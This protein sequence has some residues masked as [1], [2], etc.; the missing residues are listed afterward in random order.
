[1]AQFEG[2]RSRFGGGGGGGDAKSIRSRHYHGVGL[3]R[4]AVRI[5]TVV[6]GWSEVVTMADTRRFRGKVDRCAIGEWQP[7]LSVS[8]NFRFGPVLPCHSGGPA[9]YVAVYDGSRRSQFSE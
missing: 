4:V 1:M 9:P 8:H 5:K 7:L 6:V 3:A 2:R